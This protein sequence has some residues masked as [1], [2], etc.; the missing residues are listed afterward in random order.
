MYCGVQHSFIGVSSVS[1]LNNSINSSFVV[2][3]S[4]LH[5]SNG[6]L[7]SYRGTLG[8]LALLVHPQILPSI[9]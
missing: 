9:P 8:F 2:V 5:L 4:P 1:L 6:P 7:V 3:L